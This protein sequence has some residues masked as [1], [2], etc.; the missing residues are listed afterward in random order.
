MSYDAP[1]PPPPGGGYGQPQYGGY[2]QPQGTNKK[3]MWSM[4]LGIVS[5]LCCGLFAGIPA[6]ILSRSAKTE[7]AATGQQGGG[8]ATAGLVLGILAC[9]WSVIWVILL[10]TGN[11]SF[12]F[13]TS[14][15]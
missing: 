11:G 9:V 12:S 4:I 3:A 15:G 1:P 10:L 7:I 13:E 5:L 6:I 2:G 8:M 14:T